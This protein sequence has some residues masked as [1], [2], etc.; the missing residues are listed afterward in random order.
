MPSER[1]RRLRLLLDDHQPG[2]L[3]EALTDDGL[4]VVSLTAEQ[5]E[6]R[7]ADGTVVLRAAVA[8]GRVVVTE[9]VS[10]FGVAASHVPEHVGI[11]YCH[12]ARFPRTRVCLHVLRGAPSALAN[13]P[14]HG[15]GEQPIIWWLASA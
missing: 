6:L 5:P 10:T 13:E 3:A 9:D 8:E 14:P 1:P 15:L 11:V 2:W 12:H 4:D 7:G